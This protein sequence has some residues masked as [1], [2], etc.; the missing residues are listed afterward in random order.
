MYKIKKGEEMG[1]N[2]LNNELD[3]IDKKFREYEAETHRRC[4]FEKYLSEMLQTDTMQD[5]MNK[6][7]DIQHDDVSF[8]LCNVDDK[9][10]KDVDSMKTTIVFCIESKMSQVLNQFRLTK[11]T[12]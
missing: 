12:A 6:Y 10:I 4:K 8:T 3:F 2:L 7:K 5:L 11:A 9:L 1:E